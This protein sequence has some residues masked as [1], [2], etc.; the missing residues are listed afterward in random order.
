MID[1]HILISRDTPERWVDHALDMA[2]RAVT[3]APVPVTLHVIDGE[4]GHIGRAR[5]RGYAQGSAPYVT[6]V[7]DDDWLDAE[8]FAGLA[9]VL[10][11]N[12]PAVLCRE[13]LWQNGHGKPG[14]V[15]HHLTIVR[16]DQLIDH[17]RWPCCGDVVQNMKALRDP[18]AARVEGFRY[19]HRLYEQSKARVMRRANPAEMEAARGA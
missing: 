3:R 12:P 5:A 9:E 15:G 6:F 16:R 11:L 14:G 4:P 7:D 8:A 1:L 10:A 18:F 19:H 17:T 13:T 2:M